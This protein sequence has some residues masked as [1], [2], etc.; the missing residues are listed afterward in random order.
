M[1][2]I[3]LYKSSATATGR[4]KLLANKLFKIDDIASYLATI[5]SAYVTTIENFQY[6]KTD[7]EVSIKVDLSQVNAEAQNPS[8]Y[9]YVSIQ[10]ATNGRIAYYYVKKPTQR[11]KNCVQFDLVLDVLNTYT[12]G[13]DYV[14]KPNTRIIREHKDRLLIII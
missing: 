14:F 1:S 10:N 6:I 13:T 12:D 9:R 8:S 7:L 4:W 3:K 11:S 2:T 5:P